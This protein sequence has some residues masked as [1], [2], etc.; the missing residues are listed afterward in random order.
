MSLTFN[1]E[2]DL[3][4]VV[5]ASDSM[6]AALAFDEAWGFLIEPRGLFG[7]PD[8]VAVTYEE[9]LEG[10]AVL[11]AVAFEL[12]LSNW[13]RALD[14]AFRYKS[15]ASE[16]YVLMDSAKIQPALRHV[17]EFRRANVGL[18]AIDLH[19]NAWIYFAPES[20]RPFC[21]RLRTTF[22]KL[23]ITTVLSP[24]GTA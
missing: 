18:A 23:V 12:K 10:K 20:R 13:K 6:R 2:E 14:Q 19:G 21:D 4:Q 3:R 17:E 16:S 15:F 22:E 11:R 1:T 5:L 8:L 7:I 9:D 24:C